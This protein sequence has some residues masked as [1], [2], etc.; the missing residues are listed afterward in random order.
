MLVSESWLKEWVDIDLDTSELAT[1][2]TLS[3]LEVETTNPVTRIDPSP[4]NR[5]KF[6]VGRIS[7]I[8]P[9]PM[10]DRLQICTVEIGQDHVIEIDLTPNRG[11]CLCIQGVAREI[12]AL[13]GAAMKSTEVTKVRSIS[14]EHLPIRLEA[15]EACSRFVGRAIHDIDMHAITPDWMQEK[16]R[17]SGL[18]SINPVVDITN[19]VM[20]EMGQPMHAYDF[21]KLS[22][23]IVVRMAE[24][25]ERLKLL[26]G[27]TITL[28]PENLVIADHEKAVG[29]AGIMG[30]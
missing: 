30:G 24:D 17:R 12:S 10:A 13:T 18:R 9:H 6:V 27:S 23:G 2:L 22:G 11:D 3:G 21:D 26:D 14:G 16:L 1:K 28:S 5:K 7:D 19:L 15:P 4:S 25:R 8:K 20:L 29:L